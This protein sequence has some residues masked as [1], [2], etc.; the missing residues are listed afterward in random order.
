MYHLDFGKFDVG[1]ESVISFKLLLAFSPLLDA[2][3]EHV[4]DEDVET[5]LTNVQK[6]DQSNFFLFCFCFVFWGLT[7]ALESYFLASQ[8]CKGVNIEE[9]RS[10]S[11]KQNVDVKHYTISYKN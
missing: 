10:R 4:N 5:V 2:L 3:V 9:N 7:N 11:S 1:P 6:I 8:G